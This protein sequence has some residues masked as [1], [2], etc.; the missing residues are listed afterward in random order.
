MNQ[1]N[2][3]WQLATE[4]SLQNLTERKTHLTQRKQSALSAMADLLTFPA[5]VCQLLF[6][7]K[8]TRNSKERESISWFSN[9]LFVK[10]WNSTASSSS[11]DVVETICRK[12]RP[13]YLFLQILWTN[14][15][16]VN[17]YHHSFWL[18]IQKLDEQLSLFYPIF[19]TDLLSVWNLHF[20]L[21][22]HSVSIVCKLRKLAA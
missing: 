14:T 1:Y 3:Q 22:F 11:V 9:V 4:H 20:R 19:H 10:A 17:S 16:S 7:K 15:T 8:F 6:H 5:W 21:F 12:L 18:M 2:I 13:V